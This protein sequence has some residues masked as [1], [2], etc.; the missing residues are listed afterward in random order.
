MLAGNYS[1]AIATLHRALAA[2]APGSLT[3]AYAL[4]DLGRSLLLAG[5]PKAAIGVLEQRLKIPNQTS[6]VQ[7]TL[8]QALQAAGEAPQ[9][10]TPGGA[11]PVAARQGSPRTATR[12]PGAGN[13][14]GRRSRQSTARATTTGATAETSAGATA[15]AKPRSRRAGA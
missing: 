12:R 7:Q 11:A 2:A 3:Y 10:A 8:D 9:Q 1:E 6:I 15:W 4:Y 14:H 5:D 13:G